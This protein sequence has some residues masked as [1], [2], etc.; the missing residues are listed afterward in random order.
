[1]I[2]KILFFSALIAIEYLATTSLH[3][4]IVETLW[5]KFNH[6]FAF[7]T[8]MV[9]LTLAYGHLTQLQRVT[10]LFAFGVQ[11][12]LV[13]AFLPSRYFSLLDIVADA[14]G[15]AVGIV[16]VELLKRFSLLKG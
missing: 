12:E 9:L 13:Q 7:A 10:L 6:F 11:I 8:L 14:I 4:E 16:I 15:I 1:M 5:D 3:I 2:Y